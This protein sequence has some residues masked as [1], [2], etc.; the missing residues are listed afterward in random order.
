MKLLIVVKKKERRK[1]D[2]EHV[3]ILLIKPKPG[4]ILLNLF[5]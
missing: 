4:W 1:N 3:S 5:I 2:Q